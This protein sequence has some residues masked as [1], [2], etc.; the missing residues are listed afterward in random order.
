MPWWPPTDRRRL[1]WIENR[2][3]TGARR[4]NAK[5][6]PRH[7]GLLELL[8]QPT[9]FLGE[10]PIGRSLLGLHS[11]PVIPVVTEMLHVVLLT[12]HAGAEPPHRPNGRARLPALGS[13]H[14]HR[15]HEEEQEG[16][17]QQGGADAV[18]MVPQVGDGGHGADHTQNAAD[19]PGE[20]ATR[21]SPGA[22]D[23]CAQR[24][25]VLVRIEAAVRTSHAKSY[26][27]ILRRRGYRNGFAENFRRRPPRVL[28]G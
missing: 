19:D 14:A 25:I 4:G 22:L 18:I 12:I 27:V 17:R 9:Q 6:A 8:L 28:Q 26:P 3:L 11:S 10:P 7:L 21:G 2:R 20:N 5:G 15:G 24:R 13:P 23:G 16:C 1:R